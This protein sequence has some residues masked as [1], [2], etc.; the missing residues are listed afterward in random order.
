MMEKLSLAQKLCYENSKAKQLCKPSGVSSGLLRKCNTK[1]R[2]WLYCILETIRIIPLCIPS[3]GGEI[4]LKDRRLFERLALK[5][6]LPILE[7]LIK[8]PPSHQQF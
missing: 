3:G 7:Y 1:I 4:S 5:P 6:I 8:T 2:R